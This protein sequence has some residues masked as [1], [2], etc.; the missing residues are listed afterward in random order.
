MKFRLIILAALLAGP[1][2]A[3]DAHPPTVEEIATTAN[4]TIA[5]LQQ[6]R[7]AAMDQAVQ[8]RAQMV[9]TERDL[10]KARQEIE[11][12]RRAAY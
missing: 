11:A 3:E 9:K 7:N 4:D 10:A 2:L 1:A 8:L 5:A 6:Q 12:L